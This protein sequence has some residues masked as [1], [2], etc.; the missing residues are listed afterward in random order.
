MMN[1]IFVIAWIALSFAIASAGKRREI[2]YWTAFFVSLLLSPLIALVFLL[3]SKEK[4]PSE[5]DQIQTKIDHA[6][7]SAKKEEFKKNNEQALSL[8]MDAIFYGKEALKS[9]VILSKE[10]NIKFR[11]SIKSITNLGG[12]VSNFHKILLDDLQGFNEPKHEKETNDKMMLFI[13]I[14]VIVL[15]LVFFINR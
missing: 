6:I 4:K 12:D 10:T 7:E 2:G 9:D 1:I 5:I 13:V 3:L 14:V 15:I 8:Y 11:E